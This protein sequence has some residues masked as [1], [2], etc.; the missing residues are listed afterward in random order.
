[1]KRVVR[2]DCLLHHLLTL[3]KRSIESSSQQIHY[4]IQYT[5]A[6]HNME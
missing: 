4:T 2:N 3:T 1:M 5:I 6:T